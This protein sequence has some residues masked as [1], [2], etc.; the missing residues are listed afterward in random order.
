MAAVSGSAD[1]AYQKAV[2]QMASRS[3]WL[4]RRYYEHFAMLVSA[5]RYDDWPATIPPV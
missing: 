2:V 1:R 5:V 3:A 4:G